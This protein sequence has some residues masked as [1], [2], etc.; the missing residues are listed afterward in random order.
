MKRIRIGLSCAALLLL[1]TPLTSV[2]AKAAASDPLKNATIIASPSIVLIELTESGFVQDNRTGLTYG[3]VDSGSHADGSGSRTPFSTSFLGTGYFVSSDGFIVTAAH[4]GAPTEKAVTQDLVTQYL[5]QDLII[6]NTCAASDVSCIINNEDKFMHGYLLASKIA[7]QTVTVTVFTQ[8]MT[9]VEQGL[10]ATLEASSPTDTGHDTAVLKITTKDAPV[11]Q[12]GDSN[13]VQV[14]DSVASIGY[15]AAADISTDMKSALIPTTTSGTITAIK[16][17]PEGFAKGVT[18]FQTDASGGPGNS[19]GPAIEA[20]SDGNPTVVGLVSFGSTVSQ[21][22]SY[23]IA[24]NEIKDT[25][26]QAG[27]NN[28]LGQ[29]DQLWRQGIAYYNDKHYKAAEQDFRQCVVLNPAQVGCSKYEALA[30]QNFANDVPLPVVPPP[31][32][33]SGIPVWV[34]IAAGAGVLVLLAVA[35]LVVLRSRRRRGGPGSTSLTGT[36]QPALPAQPAPQVPSGAAP[37]PPPPPPPPPPVSAP[38][39]PPPVAA[40]GPPQAPPPTG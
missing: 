12:V 27:V 28:S 30:T 2:T 23:Y 11:L 10:P 29:I 34:W 13:S 21:S 38:T 16:T 3:V 8:N 33:S 4:V 25:M 18:V 35:V 37:S 24:G 5:D 15:P 40:G 14:Q 26:H 22:T 7:E 36:G 6:T 19:G 9:S 1:L 17:G 20:D 31:S 39:G 32:S